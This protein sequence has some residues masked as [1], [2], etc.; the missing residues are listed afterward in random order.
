MQDGQIA[1]WCPVTWRS[2][3]LP[4]A[5]NS[6]LGAEA[7][8]FATASSTVE[9]LLLLLAETLDGPLDIAKCRETLGRRRPVLVTDCKS[10]YDHLHSPSSPTSIEDRRTSIDVVIIRESCRA[11]RAHV[12]W[13]PT[14][15]ML[16]D[17]FT[18]DMGDPMDLLR[19]C[20]KKNQYQISDEETVLKNQAAEKRERLKRRNPNPE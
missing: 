3:K 9:W 17:A 20:M 11:T 2:Y 14:S 1:S 16:A 12:R 10:L 18:K 4:R 7:Q 19:S 13:V 6:T 8:A 15:W 5:V